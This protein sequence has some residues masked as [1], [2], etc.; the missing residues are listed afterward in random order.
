[1][2]DILAVVLALLLFAVAL[3][4]GQRLL[5]VGR[6][7]SA[8]V[9]FMT[10]PVP[11]HWQ[12]TVRRIFPAS[13]R[14]S[15]KNFERLLRY[16]QLFL[17]KKHFEG[18]GGFRMTEEAKLLIAAQACYLLV[19]THLPCYPGTRV[20]IVYPDA[21]VARRAP[22]YGGDFEIDEDDDHE[23]TLGE[24]WSSGAVVLAWEHVVHGGGNAGDGVNVVFHEFAHQLDQ[25]DGES[26]GIPIG[27]TT[28]DARRWEA[29]TTAEFERL[30]DDVEAG[31]PTVLDPYGATNMAEFFAV[32]TETFF[33]K[34]IPLRDEHPEL[35]RQLASFYG[36]DP[37]EELLH[38][39][40]THGESA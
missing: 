8:E 35:Y 29:V 7:S 5:L 30:C 31:R 32:A 11:I 17:T 28:E 9:G 15:G 37:V 25:A 19:G 22:G 18:A 1:M 14:L 2:Q 20:V 26:G 33:E 27:L 24:A 23:A 12:G 36:R 6:P 21:F 10:L 4:L 3:L 40:R 34:P 13:R 38:Y 39:R 16:M